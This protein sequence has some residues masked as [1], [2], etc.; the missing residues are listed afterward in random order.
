MVVTYIEVRP[1]APAH[2]DP[3][4]IVARLEQFTKP[5]SMASGDGQLE[6]IRGSV[7]TPLVSLPILG[8]LLVFEK[9]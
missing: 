1:K 7:P 2:L 8:F 3:L 6:Y 9:L 4:G 5:Y